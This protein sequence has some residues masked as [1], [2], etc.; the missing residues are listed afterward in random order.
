M[1]VITFPGTLIG[2]SYDDSSVPRISTF[3]I[4]E[5]YGKLR[6][7][8]YIV[9]QRK[10]KIPKTKDERKGEK[11]WRIV[12]MMVI[13]NFYMAGTRRHCMLEGRRHNQAILLPGGQCKARK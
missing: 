1:L 11:K 9:S 12:V 6:K 8:S 2:Y 10:C 13:P 4:S 5:K 3:F 7:D